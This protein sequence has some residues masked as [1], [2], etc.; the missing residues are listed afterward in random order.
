MSS[1]SSLESR[2]SSKLGLSGLDEHSTVTVWT[3]G[4][5][6]SFLACFSK[7]ISEPNTV[8]WQTYLVLIV[9]FCAASLGLTLE[10]EVLQVGRSPRVAVDPKGC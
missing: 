8:G 4:A 1:L 6:V 2:S 10:V 9:C 7:A 5:K 3:T